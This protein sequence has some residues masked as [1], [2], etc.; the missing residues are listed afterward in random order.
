MKNTIEFKLQYVIYD[1]TNTSMAALISLDNIK[2]RGKSHF[3]LPLLLI[4]WSCQ[5]KVFHAMYYNYKNLCFIAL[6]G[7]SVS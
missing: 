2:P 7:G 4:L 6:T 3:Q 1:F 5:K